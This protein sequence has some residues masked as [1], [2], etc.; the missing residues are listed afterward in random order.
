MHGFLTLS[1]SKNSNPIIYQKSVCYGK[2]NYYKPFPHS[3]LRLLMERHKGHGKYH[4]IPV[5]AALQTGLLQ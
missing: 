2:R 1:L 3:V 5:P 4:G